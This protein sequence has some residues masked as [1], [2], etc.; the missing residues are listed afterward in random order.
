MMRPADGLLLRS[1]VVVAPEARILPAPRS[2]GTAGACGRARADA[3]DTRRN[4][5]PP[6]VS[7]GPRERCEPLY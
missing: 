4:P 7:E 6:R 3:A 5:R 2:S 1:D